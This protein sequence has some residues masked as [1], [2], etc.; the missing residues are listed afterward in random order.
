MQLIDIL[1]YLGAALTALNFLPQ[2]LKAWKT[3]NVD[4]LSFWMLVLVISAQIVWLAYGFTL[5]LVPVII[6][7]SSLLVMALMLLIL[8]LVYRKRLRTQKIVI[9]K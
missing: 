5:Q 6:A 8:K 3:K 4:D 1:G 7:N 9:S 2:V